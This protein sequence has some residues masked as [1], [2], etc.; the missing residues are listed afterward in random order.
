V[1]ID[2]TGDLSF[3][4]GSQFIYQG[5]GLNVAPGNGQTITSLSSAGAIYF[6]QNAVIGVNLCPTGTGQ[7]LRSRFPG[8]WASGPS[9]TGVGV[10]VCA[11][12]SGLD[13]IDPHVFLNGDNGIA[14]T[15]G[16]QINI[17]GGQFAQNGNAAISVAAG[18]SR[19]TVRGAMIGA[20]SGLTQN[21]SGVFV[22]AGASDYYHIADNAFVGQT[23]P[24]SDAGTGTHKVVFNNPGDPNDFNIYRDNTSGYLIIRGQQA[25]FSA[26][27]I[28]T[29][30]GTGLDLNNAGA[31]TLP[32]V[33]TVAGAGGLAVC[34]DSAGQLYKKAACP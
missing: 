4:G 16:A 22:A 11:G 21:G 7:I 24:I 33:P 13:L 12:V 2:S 18:V 29:P 28:V 17:L 23:T 20:I 3:E 9:A 1:F 19:W 25:G 32:G 10:K 5:T 15:G 8:L 6:D 14:L 26:F 31:P 27:R 34:I 30:A